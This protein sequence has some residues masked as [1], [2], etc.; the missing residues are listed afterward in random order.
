MYE[1]HWG[2]NEKPFENTPDPRFM[3]DSEQH[4]EGLMRLMY[5][6]TQRRG[7]AL[8]TG[9]F[10]CGKTLL[11]RAIIQQ[12]EPEKYEVAIIT[13]PAF[14]AIELL[15]KILFELGIDTM[16]E[17]RVTVLNAINEILFRNMQNDKDTVIVIDEAQMIEEEKT[18]DEIRA[19]LN[20]QLDDRFLLTL[21]LIGQPELLKMIDRLPQLKQRLS[22]KWH[23][24]PFKKEEVAEYINRRLS[25]AGADREIFTDEAIS[26]I[27]N[28]TKG[29]PRLIND[30]CD[31]SL[32]A[33]YMRKAEKI[34][35]AIVETVQ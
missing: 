18:L 14:T 20:F 28:K 30:L 31:M 24:G 10:G 32:F 21:L 12:L 1:K 22:V 7:A 34:E 13:N 8:L 2:L 25:V 5:A 6:I 29:I 35:P 15:Q 27:H 11:S 33:G 23:L 3:Y 19:L 26:L 16:S 4:Y 9:E 17:D